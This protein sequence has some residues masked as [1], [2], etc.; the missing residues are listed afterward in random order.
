MAIAY[1]G[2]LGKNNAVGA[3][4]NVLTTSG[5]AAPPGSLI[6]VT[7]SFATVADTLTSVSDSA[8]N[9]YVVLENETGTGIGVGW[10]YCVNSTTNLPIGGTITGT[11]GGSVTTEL[12]AN[13]VTGIVLVGPVDVS[14]K[15]SNGLAATAAASVATGTLSQANEILFAVIG[16]PTT[17]GA[18]TFGG[19]WLAAIGAGAATPA[20]AVGYQ[21]VASTASVAWAPT[22]VNA[23]NYVSDL[24][25]FK[26]LVPLPNGVMWDFPNPTP[27]RDPAGPS[28][29]DAG[30]AQPGTTANLILFGKDKFFGG[31]GQG[32]ANLDQPNPTTLRRRSIDLWSAADS[33]TLSL[34]GKDQFFGAA[35]QVHQNPDQ[36]NP[37]VAKPNLELRTQTGA[38]EL[39]LIGKDQ[40]FGAPGQVHQNSDQPNP[41]LGRPNL[42]LRTQLNAVELNLAGQDKFFG[43]AGQG[44]AN[45]D[46]PNPQPPRRRS[47]DL[48]SALDSYI[49][50][51]L[52]KDTFFGAPGQGVAN[53]DQPNPTLARPNLELRTLLD[54]IDLNLIGQ[55]RFFGVAGNPQR[56]FPNPRVRL[57]LRRPDLSDVFQTLL[58]GLLSPIPFSQLDWPLPILAKGQKLPSRP[59][60]ITWLE[61]LK[62]LLQGQDRFYGLGGAPN[63]DQPK[64]TLAKPNLELRSFLSPLELNLLGQDRFFGLGGAPNFDQPSPHPLFPR[65]YKTEL[66]RDFDIPPYLLAIYSRFFPPTPPTPW[67]PEPTSPTSWATES[68]GTGIWITENGDSTPWTKES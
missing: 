62:L 27:K 66:S 8:G 6:V 44:P 42:E 50:A 54:S 43:A 34:L 52:G 4:T 63:F 48:F 18:V 30:Y 51:L 24:I 28:I 35:G 49:L 59:E 5:F 68:G 9:T 41:T 53:L 26:G 37:T 64:P 3:T 61:A 16:A 36:P 39:N 65:R 58:G 13:Y 46:Q 7:V 32:P 23:V 56:D 67:F 20:L 57:D 19:S 55:D 47:V 38:V 33:Y 17:F 10:A 15:T 14:A 31:A 25:S 22:W 2:N 40:F 60:L 29:R 21:I 12:T 1:G 45:L 11:F